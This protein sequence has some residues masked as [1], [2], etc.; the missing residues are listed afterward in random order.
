MSTDILRRAKFRCY[1]MLRTPSNYPPLIQ[2]H[3]TKSFKRFR[4]ASPE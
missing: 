2:A 3:S 1:E 4:A